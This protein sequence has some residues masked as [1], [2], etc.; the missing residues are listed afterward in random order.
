MIQVK[1]VSAIV[2]VYIIGVL[3]GGTFDTVWNGT[4]MQSKL[5]FLTTFTNT[6][7]ATNTFDVVSIPSTS[8][9]Y[10]Q[11]L[12]DVATL[13]FSFMQGTGYTLVYILII[14]PFIVIPGV[15][16]ILYAL[17]LMLVAI[18]PF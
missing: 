6:S 12:M 10:F 13:H 3:L 8:A 5:E 2:L 15:L 18:L 9:N 7:T 1:W 11:V 17:Y 4:E 16:A 14:L